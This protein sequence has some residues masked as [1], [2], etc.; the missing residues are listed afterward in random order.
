MLIDTLTLGQLVQLAQENQLDIEPDINSIPGLRD[1]ILANFDQLIAYYGPQDLEY[2]LRSLSI[3]CLRI[4]A[5]LYQLT[6]PYPYLNT[7]QLARLITEKV[8]S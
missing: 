3:T 6:P 7:Q 1:D 2:Y 5:E 4:I 8:F